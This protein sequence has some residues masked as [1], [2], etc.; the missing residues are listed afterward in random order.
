MLV[1]Y[2]IPD[3]PQPVGPDMPRMFR[4]LQELENQVPG[5]WHVNVLAT[6]PTQRR[7]GLGRALLGVATQSA[8]DLGLRGLSLIVLDTN[9]AARRLYAREGYAEVAARPVVKDGWETAGR[10]WILLT[11]P[12]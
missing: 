3:A 12:S 1:G 5:T 10:Q 11:R 7:R 9:G 8:R 2:P 6:D 4:P